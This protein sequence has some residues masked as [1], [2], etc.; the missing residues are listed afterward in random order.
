MIKF[1]SYDS[2]CEGIDWSKND[3]GTINLSVNQDQS[4]FANKGK[5]SVDTR[6]FGSKDDVMYGDGTSRSNSNSLYDNASSKEDTIQYYK[7]IID[8][9]DNGRRGKLVPSDNVSKQTLAAV[10]RWFTENRSDNYI[11]YAAK[12]AITRIEKE[13]NI[14][15]QTIN[16]IKDS[17]D[18]KVTRYMTG[19]VPGTDVKFISLFSMTD[20]NFSDAIKH[21]TIRQNG[22]TDDILGIDPEERRTEHRGTAL[23]NINVT[24]DNG[25]KADIKRNFSIDDQSKD[26]DKIQYA[27]SDNRYTSINQFIDK[28]VQYAS[29]VLNKENYHP[30][31]IISP[32][33]SSK[34]NEYYCTN[35]SKKLN[36]PYKSDFFSRNLINVKFDKNRD[37]TEMRNDGFSENDIMQFE[38]QIKS[39]AYK[40]IAY[41]VSQPIRKFIDDNK[42]LFSNISLK[43]HSREKTPLVDVFQSVMIYSYKIIV[44]HIQTSSDIISKQLLNNFRNKSIKIYDKKYDID[45][46]IEQVLSVIKFKI[47][48]KKFNN[49]LKETYNL[50]K[51]YSNQLSKNGYKLRF[52]SRKTK[53]TSFKKQFR[54]YL[55]DVYII[56]DKYLNKDD[57]LTSQYKNAKFLIFDEDI[58]SGATMKLCIDALQDK[59]PENKSKNIMCLVNAYSSNGW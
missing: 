36:V 49:V 8:F 30:D 22:N 43:L 50:V 20:F 44:N 21:G 35:L 56:A 55:H 14:Y 12:K 23:S 28:S 19:T 11:K 53:L 10:A 24:Y 29:Y 59:I 25:I 7:D 1:Y 38:Q 5:N 18:E 51:K 37:V 6:I 42:N 32:P 34:F 45:H 15:T 41:V 13:S 26:H 33:S 4:D 27:V 58:N 40:E 48:L 3:D 52:D 47:G 57:N 16:R 54:P 31:F 39:L 17:D 46:I 9:I 2:L